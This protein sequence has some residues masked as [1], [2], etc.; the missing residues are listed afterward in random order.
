M[1]SGN[2]HGYYFHS[3]GESSDGEWDE[4]KYTW[5]ENPEREGM[6][7][8]TE[9]NLPPSRLPMVVTVCGTKSSKLTFWKVIPS[10]G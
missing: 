5:I 6:G 4:L 8:E 3:L 1:N 2:R 10:P 7:S 9:D